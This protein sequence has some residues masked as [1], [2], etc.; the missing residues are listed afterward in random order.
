M[1]EI[2]RGLDRADRSFDELVPV[3]YDELRLLARSQLR[4]LRS[5]G[6]LDTTELV[7]E[8]YLKL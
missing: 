8:A 1:T 7:H 3:V 6:R 4:R 5:G 2:L